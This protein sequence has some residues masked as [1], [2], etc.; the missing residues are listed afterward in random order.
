MSLGELLVHHIGAIG[1]LERAGAVDGHVHV[2]GNAA[3][4]A[5]I[6][7]EVAGLIAIVVVVGERVVQ[8][9]EGTVGEHG[10]GGLLAGVV[11]RVAEGEG[12]GGLLTGEVGEVV[13]GRRVGGQLGQ[14]RLDG[15]GEAYLGGD[16]LRE[17]GSVVAHG[18]GA[19]DTDVLAAVFGGGRCER[20]D[21]EKRHG[22]DDG[23]RDDDER[24]GRPCEVETASRG[25][26]VHLGGECGACARG[27][28]AAAR[29][30]AVARTPLGAAI[31]G[32]RL[33]AAGLLAARG[34]L[35]A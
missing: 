20:T 8:A 23:Q 6:H 17:V 22:E 30:S 11:G 13:A 5:Q 21:V 15:A 9:H 31:V 32:G 3:S 19:G 27:V 29:G 28:A 10:R 34:A 26:G 35:A 14:L 16:V 12:E 18:V 25:E 7:D 24:H 1:A 2:A 33:I 4:R